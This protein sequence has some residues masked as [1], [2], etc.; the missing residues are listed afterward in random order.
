MICR[1]GSAFLSREANAGFGVASFV[2]V[3]D[4]RD[5]PLGPSGAS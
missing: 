3:G 5:G 1:A 2:V 4:A